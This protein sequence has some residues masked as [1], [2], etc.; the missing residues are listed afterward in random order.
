MKSME[1]ERLK[2]DERIY[3]N[4]PYVRR[5]FAKNTRCG[6]EPGKKLWFTGCKNRFIRELIRCYGVNPMT[7]EKALQLLEAELNNG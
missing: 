6:F 3:L 1:L 2:E 7:S 4:V 5:G